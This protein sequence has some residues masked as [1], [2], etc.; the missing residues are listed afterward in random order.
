VEAVLPVPIDSPYVWRRDDVANTDYWV[1]RLESRQIEE[2]LT[3]ARAAAASS[4]AFEET[5]HGLIPISSLVR[6]LQRVVAELTDGRGF[7]LLRGIPVNDMSVREAELACWVLGSHVG[8]PVPQNDLGDRL[9][10]V[11]DQGL[12]FAKPEV[13]GY[14]SRSRLSYHVDSSDVVALLCRRR[15]KSGGL[16]RIVSSAAVHNEM[17]ERRPELLAELYA[18]LAWDRRRPIGQRQEPGFF[19]SPVF[20][21]HLGRL[22]T[23][24]GRDYI[25]SAQR[26]AEAPRLTR[27]QIEALDLFD[28]L[29]NSPQLYLDMEFEPGDIQFLNNYMIMHSRTEYEDHE[30]PELK[31]D[32]IRL[33]LTLP[34]YPELAPEFS[35]AGLTPRGAAFTSSGA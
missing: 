7:V 15:S 27:K 3:A 28:E 8:I 17:L 32:L 26:H 19:V 2:V 29:A 34:D 6:D 33:W 18:P 22:S 12:D 21:M 4:A 5:N 30:D 10:H 35:A 31:R 1:V 23:R 11:R 14:Q 25:T 20:S 24:Y 13:F 9:L 16:S